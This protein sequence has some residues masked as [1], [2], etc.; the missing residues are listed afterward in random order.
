MLCRSYFCEL[1]SF[2]HCSS[3]H[4]CQVREL[5]EGVSEGGECLTSSQIEVSILVLITTASMIYFQDLLNKKDFS[6][7]LFA[8]FVEEEGLHLKQDDFFSKLKAWTGVNML[9]LTIITNL[10]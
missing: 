1:H 3:S 6:K 8:L 7:V 10:R 9:M 2:M 5:I 4:L